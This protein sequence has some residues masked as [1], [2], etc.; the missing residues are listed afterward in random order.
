VRH[1]GQGQ[2][3]TQA[4]A[5]IRSGVRVPQCGQV[6]VHTRSAMALGVGDVSGSHDDTA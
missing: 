3:Y 2:K 1:S 4:S 5:G 6:R